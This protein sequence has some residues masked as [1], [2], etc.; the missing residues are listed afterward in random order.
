MNI[1]LAG[2][3]VVARWRGGAEY[4][5]SGRRARRFGPQHAVARGRVSYF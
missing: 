3:M 4:A 2:C 1:K 5:R